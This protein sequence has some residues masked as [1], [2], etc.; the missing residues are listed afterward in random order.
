[1]NANAQPQVR[2][3]PRLPVR[4]GAFALA[5]GLLT[6]C[7]GDSSTPTAEEDTPSASTPAA[8]E[9]TT[10][11]ETG[12]ESMTEDSSAEETTE[13]S[14]QGAAAT[15][16]DDDDD[17]DDDLIIVIEDFEYE[18]PDSVM[19]GA[20]ITVRNEDGVGHTVTAD[21]GDAFDVVVGPGEEVTFTVP[22]EAGEY[23]FHCTPHPN[24]T[25]TLVVEG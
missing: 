11:E 9:D 7:G 17:D 19:P 13:E 12:E 18:V 24:M 21:E 4:A 15:S 22:D 2:S 25:D 10:A 3:L 5:L 20:E 6:A 1:M 23:P 16:D 8:T 14:T